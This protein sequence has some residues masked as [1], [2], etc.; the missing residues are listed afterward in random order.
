MKKSAII[1]TLFFTLGLF[2]P[3]K[4]ATNANSGLMIAKKDCAEIAF[5]L[6]GDLEANGV[7]METANEVASLVYEICMAQE[8]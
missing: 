5:N 3:L 8:L 7:D 2:A 1:L 4:A 6:Q